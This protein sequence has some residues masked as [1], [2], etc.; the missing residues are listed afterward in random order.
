[1]QKFIIER[2]VPGAGN[3]S[4]EELSALA[5][6]SN[7]TAASLGVPYNWHESFAAG[8]TIY[9]VPTRP[10]PPTSSSTTP[11]GPGF[12]V[13]KVTPVG[14]TFGPE[15]ARKLGA[16]PD[17]PDGPVPSGAGSEEQPCNASPHPRSSTAPDEP[18]MHVAFQ[19]G[20]GSGRFV[21]ARHEGV[22]DR[23]KL[24]DLR[25]GQ[26]VEH[27]APHPNPVLGRDDFD[28][29]QALSG[30]PH[31]LSPP[32]ARVRPSR[33]PAVALQPPEGMAQPAGRVPELRTPAQTRRSRSR[34]PS[35]CARGSGSGCG[36][37]PRR[38]AAGGRG[39]RAPR[40]AA[41]TN[42]SQTKRSRWSS[43]EHSHR[44]PR[45]RTLDA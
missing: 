6:Q 16:V 10:S 17:T 15:S 23:A 19:H 21:E 25:G 43:Q 36:R 39:R 9:C 7:T 26:L 18:A 11:A 45:V 28:P 32:V 12:P 33:H 20:V 40:S 2:T 5:A 44:R 42:R 35:R 13:D 24:V 41:R 1:M 37:S 8:D 30:E 22:A 3:M 4:T 27:S 38:A 14:G 31:Q 29:G 34:E